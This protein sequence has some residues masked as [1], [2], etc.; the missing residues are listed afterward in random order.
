M[1]SVNVDDDFDAMNCSQDAGS[2]ASYSPVK[3]RSNIGSINISF[4][5]EINVTSKYFL[6]HS[7]AQNLSIKYLSIKSFICIS[8]LYPCKCSYAALIIKKY[9]LFTIK[10]YL[11][12]LCG[13]F[14]VLV[15]TSAILDTIY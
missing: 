15:K 5:T 10:F 12:T 14:S 1:A 11:D 7:F 8:K 6:I 13:I 2:V 9:Q 3:R 4:I